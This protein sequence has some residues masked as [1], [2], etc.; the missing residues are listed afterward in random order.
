[1]N[2]ND[3]NTNVSGDQ[4][5]SLYTIGFGEGAED[6]EELLLEGGCN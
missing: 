2:N 1:M 5:V 3:V 6:A 4:N